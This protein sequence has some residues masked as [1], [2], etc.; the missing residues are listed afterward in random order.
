MGHLGKSGMP[1]SMMQSVVRSDFLFPNGGHFEFSK[2]RPKIKVCQ[3]LTRIGYLGK[4][5]M[6]NSMV[7]SEWISVVD[8]VPSFG[9]HS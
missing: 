3:M 9:S 5:C 8:M 4:S 7:H 6:P 2:N 1:S